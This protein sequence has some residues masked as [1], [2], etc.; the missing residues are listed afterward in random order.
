MNVKVVYV[1]V[2]F[3]ETAHVSICNTYTCITI[4]QQEDQRFQ[5]LTHSHLIR[6]NNDVQSV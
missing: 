1:H 4:P 5:K 3:W 6:V 2:Y